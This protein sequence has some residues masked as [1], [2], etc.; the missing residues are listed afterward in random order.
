MECHKCPYRGTARCLSCPADQ[1]L[2][3]AGQTFV[4]LNAGGA[5]TLGEVEA[6]L[7]ASPVDEEDEEEYDERSVA[8]GE[9]QGALKLLLYLER[10]DPGEVS[11][12]LM[13]LTSSLSDI[14]RRSGQHRATISA[15]WRRLVEKHPELDE[16]VHPHG[17]GVHPNQRPPKPPKPSKG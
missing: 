2:S 3:H 4:S 7:R 9:R 13:A 8:Y 14:A 1:P 12:L 16:I 15:R 10:L 5:Q 17:Y 11:I 6:S